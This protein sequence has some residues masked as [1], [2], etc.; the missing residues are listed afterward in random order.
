MTRIL[1]LLDGSPS[2][3]A[4]YR[5]AANLAD[6]LGVDLDAVYARHP[7]DPE[8]G[9]RP[10]A[11]RELVGEPVAVLLEELHAPDVLAGILGTRATHAKPVGHVALDIIA[12]APVPLILLPPGTSGLD[13]AKAR[14][15]VPLDGA[16]ATSNA[17]RPV[18]HELSTAG[19]EVRIVHFFDSA[20]VPP[21]V[22]TSEDLGVLADEFRLSHLPIESSACDL[23]LGNPAQHI[24][25]VLTEHPADAVVVA[26]GQDLS[27]GRAEVVR[28]LLSESPIP[29]I[30]VPIRR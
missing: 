2:S 10:E 12:A 18:I 29:L 4:V 19:A 5:A 26:W 28:R 7:D 13:I 6:M 27:P 22:A 8:Q 25:D 16:P 20:S 15:L 23:R 11:A 9:H 30:V 14:L 17:L 21:F 3:P 24:M 1:A